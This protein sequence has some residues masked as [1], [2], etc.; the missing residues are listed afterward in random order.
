MCLCD[1]C[2]FIKLVINI[3]L[4]QFTYEIQVYYIFKYLLIQNATC[5][6]YVVRCWC[7]RPCG[8]DF[9]QNISDCA[10]NYCA[11]K[12]GLRRCP[13]SS[14][15]HFFRPSPRFSRNICIEFSIWVSFY[16]YYLAKSRWT[17]SILDVLSTAYRNTRRI[18]LEFQKYKEQIIFFIWD[19]IFQ[20]RFNCKSK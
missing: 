4:L 15:K 6:A 12:Q 16:N 18:F 19:N 10:E 17:H 1:G 5:I 14:P 11:Y 9:R 20:C 13:S 3:V 2:V 8:L 7:S